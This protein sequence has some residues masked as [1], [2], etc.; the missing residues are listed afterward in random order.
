MTKKLSKPMRRA[1]LNLFDGKPGSYG[2]VGQSAH[3]GY[4]ATIIALYARKLVDPETG[5]LTHD[6]HETAAM[7]KRG[8]LT[9]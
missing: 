3:G 6:G 2:L 9:T 7:I 4:T 5:K 8:M 1:L